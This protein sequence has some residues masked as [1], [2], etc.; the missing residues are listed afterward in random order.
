M[1]TLL[2]NPVENPSY[3]RGLLL[4]C[5]MLWLYGATF[6]LA[7]IEPWLGKFA[8][9]GK[10]VCLGLDAFV[11]LRAMSERRVLREQNGNYVS[12]ID[13]SILPTAWPVSAFLCGS[14]LCVA[15]YLK[16]GAS[17]GQIAFHFFVVGVTLVL[18]AAYFKASKIYRS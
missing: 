16:F 15:A 3:K 1:L 6:L 14:L 5:A 7:A 18:G 12:M 13:K 8:S 17:Q 10:L 4:T 9:N 2:R 11:S